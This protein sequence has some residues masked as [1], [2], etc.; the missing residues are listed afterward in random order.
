MTDQ[1]PHHS[2]PLHRRRGHR[3]SRPHRPPRR[4]SPA[5]VRPRPRDGPRAG[6]RRR[7]GHPRRADI[8]AGHQVAG[9]SPPRPATSSL[10]GPA[11]PRRPGVGRRIRRRLGRAAAHPGQQRRHHGHPELRTPE[12]G[13]CSSPPTT[14]A[15]S[16][17][18]SACT[19]PSP[20]PGTPGSS[21]SARSATSTGRSLRR[22]R[23]HRRAVRP[24]A[25]LRPVQD[26]EHPLRR[27]G[28]PALGRRRHHRQRAQPR[29]DHGNR[30][31]PPH[32]RHPARLLSPVRQAAAC[33]GR[34]SSRAPRR[35]CCSAASPLIDGVTGR[36][37][38]DCQEAGPYQP[39]AYAAASPITRSTPTTPAGSGTCPRG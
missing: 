1:S 39:R 38:E 19:A 29:P 9:T 35:P 31:R 32:R 6:R 2:G 14:W 26:R 3:R 20:R 10:V 23:L 28:R 15:T 12:G 7:G 4:S 16:R 36:Y 33:R 5:G 30:T 11:R 21:S 37:F 27:R 25:R 24:V 22:P 13:S 18:P 8:E 34:P 17:S